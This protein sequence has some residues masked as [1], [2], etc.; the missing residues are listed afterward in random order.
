MQ[1]ARCWAAA[2]RKTFGRSEGEVVPSKV[3]TKGGRTVEE[4]E[5][6]LAEARRREAATA[7]VLKVISRSAFDLQAVLDALVESA[8]KLCGGDDASMFRLEGD[9][10]LRVAHC[11]PVSGPIG[12]VIPAICGSVAGRS[13]LE[14]RPI[15]VA[16]LQSETQD[17]PEG[18]AMARELGHRTILVVPLLR[19]GAPLGGISLRRN[20][21]APFSD[22]QIELVTTFADQAVIAIEN[23]RLFE[24]EQARTTELRARSAE[25]QQSLEYQTAI[26]NV[27][28]VI[29]RSPSELQPVLDEIASTAAKLC[30][31][32]T[33]IS[34]E[35]AGEL[36]LRAAHGVITIR[37]KGPIDRRWTAGR[38]FIDR[39]P[40][41]VHDLMTAREEFPLGYEVA[42]RAGHRTMLGIPLLREGKAIGCL[43]L[44]RA[45][46]RPFSEKQ[47]ALLQTFADQAVIAIE[48][49][50]LF[51][52]VQQ[53]NTALNVANSQLT[54]TLEQQ[55]ATSEI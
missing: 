54:E 10:L 4:L 45:V 19:Q 51:E 30:Q 23:T 37:K 40:V 39:K 42:R 3:S 47:I 8:A 35:R 43:F 22:K 28:S 26:S 20:T 14:R 48:N 31:A 15:H 53:K 50:R 25:L 29:S 52:E 18:S 32:D 44:R 34:L 12:Y 6:E 21:I 33:I 16:D 24:A 7:E 11:G 13:V 2:A 17:Y 9:T 5:R 41:H 55:T 27:L 38:A 1:G 46:V 36:H 49:T